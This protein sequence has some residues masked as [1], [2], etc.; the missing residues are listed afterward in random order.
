MRR[1]SK[2]KKK[3]SNC[4]IFDPF[5]SGGRLK[6]ILFQYFIAY[7][8]QTK[9]TRHPLRRSREASSWSAWTSRCSLKK[10]RHGN[11]AHHCGRLALYGG[12]STANSCNRWFD[13]TL[14]VRYVSPSVYRD[15]LNTW[16]FFFP[17]WNVPYGG[18]QCVPVLR[19]ISLQALWL[20]NMHPCRFIFY[21]SVL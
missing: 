12:G 10:R 6:K 3:K 19:N 4:S 13:K 8:L 9:S 15:C 11:F 16:I 5:S 2:L 18:T 1:I 7:F 20:Q 21:Q 14:Q 17:I